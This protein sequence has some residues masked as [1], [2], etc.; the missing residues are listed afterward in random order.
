VS[1][2]GRLFGKTE[3]RSQSLEVLQAA[4]GF[5]PGGRSGGTIGPIAGENLS[6]IAACVSAIASGLS[7]LPAYVYERTEA[8]R[9]EAP[10]HPVAR[11]LRLP[12]VQ[13]GPDFIEWWMAST[14][15]TGNG[16]AAIEYDAAGRA[17]QLVPLQWQNVRV[18]VSGTGRMLYETHPNGPTGPSRKYLQDDVLHLK[19]RTNDGLLGV[20]RLS[21]SQDVL[22]NA[23]EL[24]NYASAG[25]RNQGTPSGAVE[26]D[27][28]VND[29]Q[30][31]RISSRLDE[32]VRGTA[33]AKAVLI[34]DNKST[35]KSI[36][37]SPE[38]AEV[39]AS[40]RFTVEELCRLFQVPPPL[41]QSYEFNTFTNSA[42]AA[43]WF[44]QFCLAGWARK[45]EAELSRKL[46][47]SKYEIEID[48]AALLRGDPEARWQSNKIAIETGVLSVNEVR[49]AEGYGPVA[50]GEL[51]RSLG[52][53][54][55]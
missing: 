49:E 37:V 50:G 48:L 9:I 28:A 19:D 55:A 7:S 32:R 35:W 22:S 42:A 17:N 23:M 46:L 5:V 31:K 16:L 14:L 33:N 18:T 26:I 13:N 38:D 10:N 39:L 2:L 11:L 27:G 8:G 45:I 4:Y 1:L 41:V 24:Q 43:R 12:G 15:L 40:R 20:S 36:S 53:A 29:V 34:L 30:Y 21:R 52:A 3:A 51:P 25:W 54:P 6:T 47:S 44:A